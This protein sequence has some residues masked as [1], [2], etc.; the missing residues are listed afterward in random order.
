[1]W[2]MNVGDL[3]WSVGPLASKPLWNNL[4]TIAGNIFISL[5]MHVC[6]ITDIFLFVRDQKKKKNT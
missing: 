3:T 1:M 5:Y 6:S 4:C 2:I